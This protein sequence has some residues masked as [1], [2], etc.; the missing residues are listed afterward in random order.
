MVERGPLALPRIPAIRLS[1]RPARRGLVVVAAAGVAL[2]LVYLAARETSLFALRAVEV[3]GASPAV[4]ADARSALQP[5]VGTS[6]VALDSR[7]V[8]ARLRAVPSIRAARVDRAFPHTLTVTLEPERGLAVVRDGARAWL[9]AESG[10]V[11]ATI[12][13]TARPHLARIRTAPDRPLRVGTT[14][15]AGEVPAALSV[16]RLMPARFPA[17]VLYV[18]VESGSVTLVLRGGLELRLG[19]P[20]DAEAKLRAAGAVLGA[21]EPNDVALAYVDVSVPEHVVVGSEAQPESEG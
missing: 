2:A 21:L 10:R 7:D 17:R 4:E 9:I 11:V 8:E 13:P 19:P 18:Q 6:L 1:V 12:H 14:I 5:I 20:T 16:L 15:A 3:A